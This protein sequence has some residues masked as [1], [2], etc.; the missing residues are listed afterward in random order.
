MPV[1]NRTI[2]IDLSAEETAKLLI[3]ALGLP[4]DTKVSFNIGHQS[5]PMDRYSS[6]YCNKVSLSYVQASE[7]S[8]ARS[9]SGTSQFDD[10]D[11]NTDK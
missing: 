7:I 1:V 6:P 11:W 4:A 2:T 9:I 8:V 10:G 3:T 5:D